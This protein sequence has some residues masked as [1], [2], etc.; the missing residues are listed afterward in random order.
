MED[1]FS[2]SWLSLL[3]VVWE[4]FCLG[5]MPLFAIYFRLVIFRAWTSE[6]H[7]ET[8]SCGQVVCS[9]VNFYHSHFRAFFLWDG[10]E[11]SFVT[12]V[13]GQISKHLILQMPSPIPSVP[14]I[15]TVRLKLPYTESVL[16]ISTHFIHTDIL[17]TGL[18]HRNKIGKLTAVSSFIWLSFPVLFNVNINIPMFGA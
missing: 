14:V 4:A 9:H 6:Q 17:A 3:W 12:P 13:G 18:K 5:I 16:V 1:G 11:I 2:L 7:A 15:V 8:H 10:N